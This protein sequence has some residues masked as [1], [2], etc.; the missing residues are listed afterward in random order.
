MPLSGLYLA[1]DP[2]AVASIMLFYRGAW[3]PFLLP[4]AVFLAIAVIFGRVFC[5]WACPI[6]FLSDIPASLNGLLFNRPI[7]WRFEGLQLGV[8]AASLLASLMA[9]D[10]LSFLDP[11]AIFQR[12]AYLVW[13][14]AG[15]PFILLLIMLGSML[16]PRLWCRL[17]PMGALL[18]IF[19]AFSPFRRHLDEKCTG[20]MKCRKACSMGAISRDNKWDAVA[21]T[22]CLDCER[23][24]PEGALSYTASRPEPAISPSRR[25]VLVAGAVLG[26][27]AVSKGAA[28]ALSSDTSPVRP[29]G[30]LAEAKFNAA[31]IRCESCARACLGKVIR[32]AGLDLGLERFYTPA[33]DFNAGKCERCGTCGAVCPTGAILSPPDENIKI[34]TASID[35]RKCLAWVNNKKCLIC[36]EVCPVHAVLDT[37]LLKPRIDP[38]VC[39]GCGS[40]QYNCP[41]PEKAVTVSSKGERRRDG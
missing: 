37:S 22:R 13:G 7:K 1:A 5:A 41:V 39:I 8:L 28:S 25:S 3:L 20:C 10:A 12:S 17:C 21:C 24:C 30:S 34:G 18:G 4:A 38:E 27:F 2:L 32:P 15:V 14:L 40:C 31:C 6:G 26:L 33:L 16:V 19:S 11:M 23:A 9:L 35:G 36:A 29:P